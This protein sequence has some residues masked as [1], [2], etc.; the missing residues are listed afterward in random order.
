MPDVRDRVSSRGLGRGGRHARRIRPCERDDLPKVA[1]LYEQVVRSGSRVPPPRLAEYFAR[2]FFDCPWA[3]PEIPSLVFEETDGRIVGFMGSHVR[4]LRLDGRAIRVACGGQLVVEPAARGKAVGAFLFRAYLSGPQDATITD[5]ANETVRRMWEISGGEAAHL[6]SMT[7]TRMLRPVRF[8][9]EYLLDRLKRQALAPWLGPVW[10]AMDWLAFGVGA[11]R[12]R[13]AAPRTGAEPL[14]AR[15][16]LEYAPIVTASLRC[17]PDYDL[18][19]LDWLF[20]EL[21]EVKSRGTLVRSLVSDP[22]GQ[23][24]GWYVYYLHRG[25]S[26]VMQVAAK[27]GAAADVLDHLLHH[28]YVH[29]SAA[30]RGRVEPHLLGPLS[31]RRCLFGWDGAALIHSRAPAI[32]GALLSGRCLLGRMDGEWWMGHHMEPFS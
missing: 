32:A 31:T 1:S 18:P 12:F 30:V 20:H 27:Q 22:R 19:F 13:P 4:R 24:L 2:T 6:K 16:L 21:A 29:G 15:A 9:G 26:D 17:H 23:V 8:G 25:I 7:W 28:A 3:D 14:T 10:S 5:G 11:R